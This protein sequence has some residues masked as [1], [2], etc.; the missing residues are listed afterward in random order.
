MS[1]IF[2]DPILRLP[3]GDVPFPGC[4]AYLLQGPDQ[5]LLFME[6]S[7]DVDLPEHSHAGQVGFVLEGR[8]DLVIDGRGHTFTRGDRYYIRAGAKH[9]GRIHAGYA[10]I[11]FFDQAD[12]YS[13]KKTK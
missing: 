5:Q 12:R 9:S 10:D 4:R 7:E 3:Q 6:F 2:P 1:S 13:P 11:T 8:I